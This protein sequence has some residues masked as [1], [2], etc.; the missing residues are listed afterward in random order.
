MLAQSV[1]V[2]SH[3]LALAQ[4]EVVDAERGGQLTHLH[5]LMVGEIRLGSEVILRLAV[6]Y[7]LLHD[8][9]VQR[10]TERH[11]VVGQRVID[12]LGHAELGDGLSV[13]G[14]NISK[15]NLLAMAH[16]HLHQHRLHLVDTSGSIHAT[17]G[18][19]N[20]CLCGSA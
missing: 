7:S 18:A 19:G 11:S 1:G 9:V 16:N 3:L 5:I 17:L 15:Y 14:L 2:A 12:V 20:C 6:L 13:V 8:A 4:L 10:V